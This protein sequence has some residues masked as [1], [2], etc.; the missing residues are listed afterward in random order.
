M[1]V[2]GVLAAW[3][4]LA[5]L[6]T[7][8]FAL[9]G[10]IGYRRGVR[11][12]LAQIRERRAGK[13]G[14]RPLP[15]NHLRR[16]SSGHLRPG[17]RARRARWRTGPGSTPVVTAGATS[18][19][20]STWSVL[21]ANRLTAGVAACLAGLLLIGVP[22]TAVGASTAGPEDRMYGAKLALEQLRLAAAFGPERDAKAHLDLAQARLA[23][24]SLLDASDAGPEVIHR[25]VDEV[26]AHYDAVNARAAEIDEPEVREALERDIA[27]V[28]DGQKAAVDT[29]VAATG[30]EQRT[31]GACAALAQVQEETVALQVDSAATAGT[32]ATA[33]VATTAEAASVDA[34]ALG[35][36]AS[37]TATAPSRTDAA[38]TREQDDPAVGPSSGPS[39]A[40]GAA[41]STPSAGPSAATS[42]ERATERVA[43]SMAANEAAS[44]KPS[45][46]P[47]KKEATKATKPTKKQA[48]KATKPTKKQATKATK[49]TKPT[50]EQATKPATKQATKKSEPATDAGPASEGASDTATTATAAASAPPTEAASAAARG[51]GQLGGALP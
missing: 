51:T 11:D 20:G 39:A 33:D 38:A 5:V 1:R 36:T 15:A 42:S 35:G 12:T 41:T 24:L 32:V 16:R 27:V 6:A 37:D 28:V 10:S 31:D 22:V 45:P 8:C 4:V 40:A 23:E 29:M 34:G 14:C 47:T 50:K 46:K 30:C 25:V 2:L 44:S 3:G 9:G 19:T 17:A 13:A 7:M 18:T 48:T 43:T 49:A 21:T 26:E